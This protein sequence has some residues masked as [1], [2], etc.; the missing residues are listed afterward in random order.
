M[1]AAAAAADVCLGGAA[2]DAVEVGAGSGVDHALLEPQASMPPKLLKP[3]AAT[4]GGLDAG[5]GAAAG[6]ERLNAD[7]LYDGAAAA[8]GA[9]AGAGAGEARSKRSPMDDEFAGGGGE[10]LVAGSA[11]AKSPKSPKPL[12][13]KCWVGWAFGGGSGGETVLEM[14]AGLVSKKLPPL[15][16]DGDAIEDL[17]EARLANGDATGDCCLGAAAEDE[18]EEKLKPPKASPSPARAEALDCEWVCWLGET[19]PPNAS[20]VCWG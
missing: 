20:D 2:T 6:A 9:G 17:G 13:E 3:D 4:G 5:F 8:T 15:R 12:E 10:D 11:E 16:D 7:E 18:G 1:V 19:K 14:G